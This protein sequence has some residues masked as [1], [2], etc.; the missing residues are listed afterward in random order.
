MESV[1]YFLWLNPDRCS[2]FFANHVLIVEG[3]SEQALINKLLSEGAI[4]HP[5]GGLYVLDSIGKFNIHRFMNLLTHLGISH[6]VFHDDD[7]GKDEHEDINQLIEDSRHKDL[8]TAVEMLPGDLETVLGIA[9]PKAPH[10]KPQHVLF[11]YGNGLIPEDKLAAFCTLVE[12]CLPI[13]E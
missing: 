11:S 13:C 9:K 6:S 10:R 3:P 12:S 7:D 2:M 4:K 5:A 1:K 8:T